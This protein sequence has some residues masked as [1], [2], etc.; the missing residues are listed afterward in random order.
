MHSWFPMYFPVK[1]P[2]KV[3]KGQEVTITVW[4]NNSNSKVWY[5]WAMS[6]FDPA[7][8]R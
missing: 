6:V 8:N 3:F 2:I 4:R 1:E 7:L 5:E